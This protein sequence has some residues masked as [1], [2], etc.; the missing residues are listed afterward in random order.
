MT[1]YKKLY[2]KLKEKNERYL[3]KIQ[4]LKDEITTLSKKDL[5]FSLKHKQLEYDRLVLTTQHNTLNVSVGDVVF[6]RY[7]K[8]KD[9]DR[10]YYGF[11][12]KEI[13]NHVTILI[14]DTK[15]ECA[16][17]Y[18]VRKD[19]IKGIK[20]FTE[21]QIEGKCYKDVIGLYDKQVKRNH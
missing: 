17:K 7:E 18:S 2:E 19:M 5:I 20:H 1:S 4:V 21:K 3:E 15:R 10:S 14:Y 8:S 6:I 11:I 13:M 16:Y 12:H 9:K